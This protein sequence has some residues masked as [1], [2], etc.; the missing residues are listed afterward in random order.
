MFIRCENDPNPNPKITIPDKNFLKALVKL[1]V[2][3]NGDSIISP[4]EAEK[5]TYLDV[6]GKRIS[7]LSGIEAFV[8]LDTLN[9]GE[10]QLTSLD[11][12]KNILLKYLNCYYNNKITSINISKNTLLTSLDCSY[13]QLTGL[14]VSNNTALKRMW[15]MSNKLTSLDVS[16]NAALEMLVCFINQL[17]SL[18]VSKNSLLFHLSCNEN[19][20]TSLDVSNNTLLNYFDCSCTKSHP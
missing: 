4:A 17:T 6:S 19:R 10:N 2:D 8:N 13:N 9:C 15:C 14:D 1:G 20:L 11:L 3:T 5:I 16:K 7:D 18:D 12:S